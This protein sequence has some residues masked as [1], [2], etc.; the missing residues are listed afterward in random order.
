MK[1]NAVGAL[2]VGLFFLSGCGGEDN[3]DSSLI[4]P[5]P[6][7]SQPVV[8][9]EP[10]ASTIAAN[11]TPPTTPPSNVRIN[12][13]GER[14]TLHTDHGRVDIERSPLLMAF[15]DDEGKKVLS[16][17]SEKPLISSLPRLPLPDRLL[18]GWKEVAPA[19]P[20]LY[21]PFTFITGTSLH[22]QFPAT[23]WVGNMLSSASIGVE[24]RLTD[25]ESAEVLN[26]QLVMSVATSDP[27]GRKAQVTIAAA[28]NESFL[29]SVRIDRV[30]REVPVVAASFDSSPGEAFRG[31]GGRRNKIN[32][33][34]EAFLNWAEEF[35]LT[36]EEFEPIIGNVF[37]DSYQFPTGPQGAYY[38]QSLFIVDQKYGFLLDRDELSHWR[39]A[40]D[41]DDAWRV[42]VAGGELDFLVV[43]GNSREVVSRLSGINGRHRLPPRWALGPM[44][45]ETIQ[46]FTDTPEAYTSK[47]KDSLDQ[48]EQLELPVSAFAFE[49]WVGT[50]A[51][52]AFDDIIQRLHGQDIKPLTYYRAFVGQ[53][54]DELEEPEVFDEAIS[55]GYVAENV[56]GAPYIFGSPLM[57]GFAALVDFTNP[58][59]FAWWK[60]RIK[61]GLEEGSEGF[62]QDFGE[63]V[64]VDM[65]FHDGSSGIEM[66]NRNATLLHKATREAFDEFVAENPQR[67][68]WFFVRFGSSG[69]RGSAHYESASWPGDN[70]ADWSRASGLGSVI[71]DMLN[72]SVGGAYGFVTEIGGYID[73]FGQIDSELLIRWANHASLM[74]VFRQ[75]G[76][77]INGTPMPWR[78]D[79][80]EVV[81]DYRTAMNRHIA[82][83]PLIY[84]LWQEALAT[85]IP[86]NRPLWLEFPDDPVAAGQDQQFML[87]PDV[88][89]APVIEAGAEGREVYFP[90][91][92]WRHPETG[93]TVTGPQ[94]KFI[95]AAV[96]EL[97]YFFQC[98]TNPFDVPQAGF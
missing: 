72:R 90:S 77:P 40:S 94:S 62:M 23:F 42:E 86:I 68:P 37:G 32:Q 26:N 88:L 61:Q 95:L 14:I 52:G 39:M 35:S 76:G 38:T 56:L 33:R 64:Q 12:T 13:Q 29:V 18:G 6:G 65:V 44:I 43:P 16:S 89:V 58:D 3:S 54:E 69:R 45:S 2:L 27:S 19:A 9:T 92:C 46:E 87:G 70:T 75:H 17:F 74:P 22:L 30:L 55:K 93:Q 7:Q 73:I 47:V 1:H 49:G 91:G 78:F 60:E 84:A 28:E 11:Q 5:T 10:G 34:G 63:Q 24:Y 81:E 4:T 48:I 97:P 31:F 57:G 83:Q 8:D 98:D 51:T 80:P 50:K 79:D 15:Y 66:H 41:R 25:V 53:T 59:A 71:P 20:A 67:E 36:P 82:A 85:G 21:A 96:D